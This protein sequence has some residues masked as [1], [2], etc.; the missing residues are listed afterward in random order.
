V[1]AVITVGSSAYS[2]AFAFQPPAVPPPPA[3]PTVSASPIST[4]Q[5]TI[6]VAFTPATGV[7]YTVFQ[8]TRTGGGATWGA[9]SAVA[10]AL[11]TSPWSSAPVAP[12]LQYRYYL[13][14]VNAAGSSQNGTV[15]NN[16]TPRELANAPTG[17][18]ASAVTT[19][20]TAGVGT[21]SVTLNWALGGPN[22]STVTAVR[23]LRNGTGTQATPTTGQTNGVLTGGVTTTGL[24]TNAVS[25]TATGLARN[26]TYYFQV[27]ETTAGGNNQSAVVSVTTAP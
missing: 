7:T 25:A 14:A 18:A 26:T 24:A 10:T 8:Q 11:T 2:A 5:P 6:T 23:L 4:S 15:S 27:Q 12:N 9:A 20:V 16:I 22:G 13:V 17:V 21:R 19:G 3:A 1:M